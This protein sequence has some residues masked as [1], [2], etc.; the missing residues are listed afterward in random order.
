MVAVAEE[1]VV[2]AAAARLLQGRLQALRRLRLASPVQAVVLAFQG[3]QF[4]KGQQVV[5]KLAHALI[6]PHIA[7]IHRV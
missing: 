1:A 5:S 7:A 4:L 6:F 2:V 3:Q